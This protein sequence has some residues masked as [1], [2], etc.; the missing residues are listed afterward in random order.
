MVLV[1]T[2]SLVSMPLYK[3]RYSNNAKLAEGYA[4]LGA[5]KDAQINYYNEYGYFYA[6]SGAHGGQEYWT[7]VEPGLG[8]NALNNRYFTWFNACYDVS[9]WYISTNPADQYNMYRRRFYAAVR[10]S[11]V[12][13]I[14]L[15]Y[16]VSM[17]SSGPE[18]ISGSTDLSI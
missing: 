6:R 15:L 7:V 18:V 2:L 16:D 10:S 9:D 13:T 5:I 3:G 11:K 14:R 12:G 4:L 8:I 1:I 17:K